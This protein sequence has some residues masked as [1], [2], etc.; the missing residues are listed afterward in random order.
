[1][2]TEDQVQAPASLSG[3]CVAEILAATDCT[4][5]QC[6]ATQYMRPNNPNGVALSYAQCEQDNC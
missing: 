5:S 3:Q 1:M 4:T 6:V 2:T